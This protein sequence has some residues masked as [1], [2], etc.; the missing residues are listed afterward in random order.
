MTSEEA[1]I[2]RAVQGI[3]VR[4]YVDTQRAEVEVIGSCVYF[5]GEFH[6][7]DYNP[8]LRKTDRIERE[9]SEAR[10]LLHVEKQIRAMA[11]VSHIE[12]KFK[13]WERMGG[14]WTAKRR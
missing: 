2:L 9:M 4:N 13:N 11:E 14:R 7:Y 5:E 3:L 1:R 10:T 6:V 12:I 8:S